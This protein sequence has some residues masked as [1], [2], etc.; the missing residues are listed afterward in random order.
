MVTLLLSQGAHI[1]AEDKKEVRKF[2]SFLISAGRLVK[3]PL[4]LTIS[5]LLSLRTGEQ[6]PRH[7]PLSCFRVTIWE[8]TVQA[9]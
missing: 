6:T 8:Q 1:N 2:V 7:V 5:L 9:W 4:T 3:I